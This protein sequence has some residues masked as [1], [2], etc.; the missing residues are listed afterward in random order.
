MS[1]RSSG[2]L[3]HLSLAVLLVGVASAGLAVLTTTP[4]RDELNNWYIGGMNIAYWGT[5]AALIPVA[6]RVAWWIR[7][8]FSDWRVALLAHVLAAAICALLHI[9][10][11]A[12][13]RVT[14]TRWVTG[15]PITAQKIGRIMITTERLAVEWE[16][17]MYGA[18]AVFAYAAALQE[19]A[20]RRE[21]AVVELKAGLVEARLLSLQRQLQPH[22]L[23]NTL[24]A[25]SVLIRRDPATAETM[26]DRLSQLLRTTFRSGAAAEVRLADDLATLYDY[27][28]IESA[29][30]RERLSVSYDIDE[31]ALDAAVPVLLMQPLVENAVRHGL[32]PRAAGGSVR[33]SARRSGADLQIAVVDDGI[34]LSDKVSETGG[35]GLANTRSRLEQLYAGRY[36]FS[37]T[38]TDTGGVCVSLRIPFRA[39]AI[40]KPATVAS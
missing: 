21:V 24:H 34:G 35:V 17:T 15:R 2:S 36:E 13:T 25:V 4:I 20:R 11:L 27:V 37:V 9:A 3:R 30:M 32:Q 39:M 26:I 38:D 6:A 8:R 29:Q 31:A 23:F 22:F 40:A 12:T 5:W 7:A 1:D 19:E 16:F 18:I 28:A 10:T 14:L 33:V